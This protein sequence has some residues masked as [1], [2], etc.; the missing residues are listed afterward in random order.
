[1]NPYQI[2]SAI[3]GNAAAG[4]EIAVIQL[5]SGLSLLGTGGA[6]RVEMIVEPM[7]LISARTA[8]RNVLPGHDWELESN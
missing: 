2:I 8:L 5:W 7:T 4:V 1:M 3:R 6:A